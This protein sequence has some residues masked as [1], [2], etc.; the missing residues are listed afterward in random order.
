MH[1]YTPP[2]SQLQI[3]QA[4]WWLQ[5]VVST[6]KVD[7]P[8][9]VHLIVWDCHAVDAGLTSTFT[10]YINE[11][12]QEW[13]EKNNEE[14]HGEGTSAQGAVSTVYIHPLGFLIV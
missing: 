9:H 7:R 6:Q 4:C 1:P 2:T 14:A 8:S 5:R 13:L 12:D 3:Q 11:R 10:Y